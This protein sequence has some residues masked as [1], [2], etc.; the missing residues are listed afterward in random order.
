MKARTLTEPMALKS[1]AA[2]LVQAVARL[3]SADACG[4]R[5]R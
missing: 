4:R 1:L 2:M 5:A 3:C